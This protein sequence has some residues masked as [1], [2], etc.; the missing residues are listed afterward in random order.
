MILTGLSEAVNNFDAFLMVRDDTQRHTSEVTAKIKEQ[1]GLGEKN[2]E[3]ANYYTT[4]LSSE[5]PPFEKTTSSNDK[6]NVS[7]TVSNFDLN[8]FKNKEIFRQE[9]SVVFIV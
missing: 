5:E 4:F 6:T 7:F 2:P 3:L 1:K 8:P 9:L